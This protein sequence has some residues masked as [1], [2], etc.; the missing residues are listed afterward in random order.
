MIVAQLDTLL[1]RIA[2]VGVA[3]RLPKDAPQPVLVD[4]LQRQL[5]VLRDSVRELLTAARAT[6]GFTRQDNMFAID[7]RAGYSS[8][9]ILTTAQATAAGF[10]AINGL[11]IY[12]HGLGYN[13]DWYVPMFYTL[14]NRV[15]FDEALGTTAPA[16]QAERAGGFL[17]HAWDKDQTVFQL[18]AEAQL[19]EALIIVSLFPSRTVPSLSNKGKT[20]ETGVSTKHLGTTI[21]RSLPATEL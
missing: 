16:T 8:Y 12:H 1:D 17:I 4:E 6:P 15:T 13:L 9:N 2:K 3:G 5:G 14:N 18:D 20:A 19:Q 7:A 10:G 11:A 21:A